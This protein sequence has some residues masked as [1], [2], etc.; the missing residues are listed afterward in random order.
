MSDHEPVAD[1][2]TADD[3]PDGGGQPGYRTKYEQAAALCR[4]HAPLKVKVETY[5]DAGVARRNAGT[6]QRKANDGLRDGEYTFRAIG[7]D[8]WGCFAPMPAAEG[9]EE[10]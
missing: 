6:F 7:G 3:W 9:G 4:T 10:G 8:V 1:V 5:D 2:V